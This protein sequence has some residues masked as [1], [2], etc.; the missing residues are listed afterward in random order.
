MFH[1]GND[2]KFFGFEAKLQM[3]QAEEIIK[4]LSRHINTP[5]LMERPIITMRK[6]EKAISMTLS[7]RKEMHPFLLL[8]VG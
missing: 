6:I 2:L 5:S 1:H 8:Q 3:K 7:I 4:N